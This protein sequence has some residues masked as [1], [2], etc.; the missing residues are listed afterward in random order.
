AT[1]NDRIQNFENSIH[2][3]VCF[4]FSV[5]KIG[6]AFLTAE[7]QRP[8]R[9]RRVERNQLAV[10]LDPFDSSDL[11]TLNRPMRRSS[12]SSTSTSSPRNLNCS[13]T[14]GTLPDSLITSPAIVV[15]SSASISI[16]KRRSIFPIS[17]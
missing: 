13:P 1:G 15:K 7:T 14:G 5:V 11:L 2:D 9:L 4:L 16:S 17:V 6:L 10:I 3:W 12:A 8:P